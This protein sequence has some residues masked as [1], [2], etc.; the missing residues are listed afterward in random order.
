VKI[1][2]LL[3]CGTLFLSACSTTSQNISLEPINLVGNKEAVLT[4]WQVAKKVAP[5][6]PQ[7]AKNQRV[8]GCVEFSLIIDSTGKAINPKIIK[9]FPKNV[10]NKQAM[11]AIKKWKWTPTTANSNRQP[12]VTTIQHDFVVKSSHN[13]NNAYKNCKI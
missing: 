4:Y 5:G 8:S 7:Q 9:A 1:S 11:R 12:V 3:V 2:Y 10:F 13:G 6:Y